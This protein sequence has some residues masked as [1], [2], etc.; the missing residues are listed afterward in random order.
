MGVQIK[1][2]LESSR[3]AILVK[4]VCIFADAVD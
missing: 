3:E 1:N 2:L 4:L